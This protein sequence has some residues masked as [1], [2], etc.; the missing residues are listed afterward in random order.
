V[1]RRQALLLPAAVLLQAEEPR[2]LS[3]PLR[4]IEGS[5]TPADMF[6][7]RDHFAEP[8][9]SLEDWTLKIEGQVEHPFELNFSDLLESAST[10]IEAVLECAGNKASGSAASNGTWEG[11]P[12]KALLE[13]ARAKSDAKFV[14]LEAADSGK[15]FPD[16][17]PAPYVQLLPIQKCTDPLNLVAYKLNGRLLPKGNGFPARALFPGWYAMDSV[18]WLRRIVVLNAGELSPFTESG[19][20]RL[21]NR[22]S[23]RLTGIQVKS[24]VAWPPNDQKL[25]AGKHTVWGFA[26][27]GEGQ[28][29]TVSVTMDGGNNWS[30]AK[31]DTNPG[32][33]RW[34]R[35]SFTWA[36]ARGEYVLMS[37]AVDSSGSEQPLE[38][39]PKRK[40]GYELNWCLPVRCRVV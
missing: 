31:L 25:P 12:L 7:I 13:T 38:R 36:A 24:A 27:T 10:K 29:R 18:K 34:V 37:R 33:Y 17:P 6:F 4:V 28:I 2:N 20:N 26:W 22:G 11:V 9:V 21:Y 16:T 15:L 23:V 1:T 30:A 35:W 3:Y 5:I 19:M 39:D 32:P 40:D 14:L 8:D